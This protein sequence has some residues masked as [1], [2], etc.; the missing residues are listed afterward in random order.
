[1]FLYYPGVILVCKW[2]QSSQVGLIG[3]TE[4]VRR[5]TPLTLL[6]SSFMLSAPQCA[7][8]ICLLSDLLL[9]N[10]MTHISG[11]E[12]PSQTLSSL[13]VTC[14]ILCMFLLIFK[15]QTLR[16]KPP[17]WQLDWKGICSTPQGYIRLS[18]WQLSRETNREKTSFNLHWSARS[19]RK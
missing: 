4:A 10:H 17:P 12:P 9:F 16:K 8:T 18:D 1:M 15:I 3:L 14:R 11:A 19:S 13:T 2:L 7:H 6:A 5:Q